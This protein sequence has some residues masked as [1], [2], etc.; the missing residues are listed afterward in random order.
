MQ[1]NSVVLPAPFGPIRPQISPVLIL[2]VT[3]S[4]ARTPPK[5]AERLLIRSS[6]S[7]SPRTHYPPERLAF[8]QVYFFAP[9]LFLYAPAHVQHERAARCI[10]FGWRV[11]LP[12]PQTARRPRSP[13]Q[14]AKSHDTIAWVPWRQIPACK[15]RSL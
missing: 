11:A 12:L 3:L 1:L 8:T 14:W 5:R 6:A 4:S 7:R 13:L 2:H 10:V 9:T 15:R